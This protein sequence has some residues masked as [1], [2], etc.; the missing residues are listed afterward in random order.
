MLL[1]KFRGT[2]GE[3]HLRETLTEIYESMFDFTPDLT[4]TDEEIEIITEIR[5]HLVEEELKW[6][7]FIIFS[8]RVVLTD[9]SKM[10]RF[11]CKHHLNSIYK[12]CFANISM[13]VSIRG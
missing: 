9:T 10:R 11:S 5:N 4:N 6:F 3:T 12:G 2:I 8:C 13:S 1:N 7:V